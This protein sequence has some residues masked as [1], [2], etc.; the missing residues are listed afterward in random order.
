MSIFRKPRKV[1]GFVD[2]GPIL[3]PPRPRRPALQDR[4]NGNTY[5]IVKSGASPALSVITDTSEHQVFTA[6]QGPYVPD[7][8]GVRPRTRRLF[9][10]GGSLSSEQVAFNAGQAP[11][12]ITVASSP[13]DVWEVVWDGSALTLTEVL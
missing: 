4:S 8:T 6:N 7:D 9:A 12:L 10:S 3:V 1:M 2:M 11:V 5:E 13:L